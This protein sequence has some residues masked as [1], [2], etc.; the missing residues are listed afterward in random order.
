MTAVAT[1]LGAGVAR[2][3]VASELISRGCKVKIIDP[4]GAPGPHACSWWA[5]GMLAPDCEGE[6]AEELIVRL[7][8]Q[9]ANWWSDHGAQVAHKGLVVVALDSTKVL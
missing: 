9:A 5:G 6:V 2:L 7:G 1:I 8:R 4:K 3:C